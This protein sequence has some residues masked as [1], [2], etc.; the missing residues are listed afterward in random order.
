MHFKYVIFLLAIGILWCIKFFAGYYIFAWI[1]K[2]LKPWWY[3]MR[4]V[5]PEKQGEPEFATVLKALKLSS[6]DHPVAGSAA[7]LAADWL[8]NRE[9]VRDTT[10]IVSTVLCC[11]TLPVETI[12]R[13]FG[14]EVASVVRKQREPAVPDKSA[15][16]EGKQT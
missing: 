15:S 7:I 1:G 3:W 4:G 2:K 11:T 5:R 9:G 14:A 6:Q 8:Y 10:V 13:E 16:E 12:E